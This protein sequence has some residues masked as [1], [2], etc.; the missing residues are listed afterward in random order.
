MID[1]CFLMAAMIKSF[2]DS[3]SNSGMWN[4]ESGELKSFPVE[5]ETNTGFNGT[6]ILYPP[7]GDLSVYALVIKSD[8][9]LP[10]E[11]WISWGDTISNRMRPV[12]EV[13]FVLYTAGTTPTDFRQ[14]T[15]RITLDHN[16]SL[17]DMTS[18]YY[19]KMTTFIKE[20]MIE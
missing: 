14:S 1:W 2:G 12:C 13:K 8:P 3:I 4:P 6:S 5:L 9:L 11:F 19:D 17:G 15:L 20:V 10:P 7:C 18:G 16:M